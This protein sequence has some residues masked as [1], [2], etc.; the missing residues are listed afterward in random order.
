MSGPSHLQAASHLQ[1]ASQLEAPLGRGLF[2]DLSGE[3][4]ADMTLS[5]GTLKASFMPP[6]ALAMREL[7]GEK[8]YWLPGQASFDGWRPSL[9]G[10]S[11]ALQPARIPL[12]DHP[13]FER[14][15]RELQDWERDDHYRVAWHYGTNWNAVARRVK[16]S[17]LHAWLSGFQPQPGVTPVVKLLED[18]VSGRHSTIKRAEYKLRVQD[19]ASGLI[20][21]SAEEQSMRL[22]G[23]CAAALLTWQL[24][25]PTLRVTCG[26]QVLGRSHHQPSVKTLLRANTFRVQLEGPALTRVHTDL[27]FDLPGGFAATYK[28][29]IHVVLDELVAP[30]APLPGLGAPEDLLLVPREDQR[31]QALRAALEPEHSAPNR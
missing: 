13:D 2:L 22:A 3:P 14:V 8:P 19:V 16:V 9:M 12:P 4:C 29:E 7:A 30:P 11:W 17:V 15:T 25:N 31:S 10:L 27:R 5:R 23:L 26:K 24:S 28:D 20:H 18:D 1:R 6:A 21:T